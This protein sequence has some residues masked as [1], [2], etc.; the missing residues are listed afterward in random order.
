M[1]DL[2]KTLK[3]PTKI[4]NSGK[5]RGYNSDQ[6]SDHQE[7]GSHLQSVIQEAPDNPAASIEDV[8]EHSH[9]CIKM[10]IIDES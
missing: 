5:T 7:A 3:V 6:D 9:N 8:L 4:L 10:V 2:K 1:K